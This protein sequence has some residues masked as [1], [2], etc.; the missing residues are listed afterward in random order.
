MTFYDRETEQKE[1]KRLM[2]LVEKTKKSRMLVV[3]GRRRV[4][5]TSLLLHTCQQDRVP[6][7]YFF[8]TKYA[9][10]EQLA[11]R[12]LT[13]IGDKLQLKYLPPLKRLIDVLEFV[14]DYSKQ[15][16]LNVIIDECQEIDRF[17]PAFWSELQRLW[18]LEKEGSQTLLALSG[19]IAS[20]MRHIFEDYSEPLFGRPDAFLRI[21]AFKTS[22][23]EEILWSYQPNATND[24]LLALYVIT[25]GVAHY[26]M[27][28]MDQEAW[29]L[30]K[31]CDVVFNPNSAFIGEG[32]VMLANEFKSEYGVYFALLQLIARGVTKRNELQDHFEGQISGQL[33]RLETYYELINKSAPLL[34]QSN[35]RGLR[36]K[37]NDRFLMFW[38]SFIH[39]QQEKIEANNFVGL[40]EGFKKQYADFSGRA[41]EQFFLEKLRESGQYSALGQWWSRDGQVE[42]DLIAI[43]ETNQRIR[44]FEIKRNPKKIDINAL[45]TKAASFFAANP[46]LR[47]YNAT[48]EGLSLED[49]RKAI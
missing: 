13:E 26:V 18:D 40:K 5:K 44:F 22:V 28:M 35:Q 3:T 2:S 12:W 14:L 42:I 6:C 30:D 34:G 41:L 24:D 15:Q 7:L 46:K 1:I 19:S 43:D 49:M 16:R 45:M 8:V 10:E 27:S 9:L 23:L 32:S 39:G 36:F 38:F 17:R 47:N 11:Q 4:G 20:A 31:I 33:Q 48:Y 25:G 37:M 21:Q 29:N